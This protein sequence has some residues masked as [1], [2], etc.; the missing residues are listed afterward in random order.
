M[1]NIDEAFA[2]LSDVQSV[3][4]NENVDFVVDSYLRVISIPVRGVVLGVEGDKDVNRVTF[5]MSRTY[6]GVD[7]S[8]FQIRI[9]YAN[10]NNELN[11]FKVTEI[12]VSDDEI[13]FVWVVGADAVAYVGNVEFVVRFIKLSGSNIIQELNTTLATAKSLIGLSV[14]GEISPVQREDLLAHFYN[15]IDAYSETKKNEI[16]DSIPEDYTALANEVDELKGDLNDLKDCFD[17]SPNLYNTNASGVLNGAYLNLSDGVSIIKDLSTV[18]WRTSDF[19]DVSNHDGVI[20]LKRNSSSGKVTTLNARVYWYDE[21]NSFIS[22]EN[23]TTPTVS[24]P[25]NARYVRIS[26]EISIQYDLKCSVSLVDIE[27]IDDYGTIYSLKEN[28]YEKGS[29]KNYD[30]VIK[31]ITNK[32]ELYESPNLYD[33]DDT[34]WEDGY[35][36]HSG[37][38]GTGD[39]KHK[40]F[41]VSTGDTFYSYLT[42]ENGNLESYR[43]STSTNWGIRFVTAYMEDGSVNSSLGSSNAIY[44]YVVPDGVTKICISVRTNVI[45]CLTKNVDM[46]GMPYVGKV[47]PYYKATSDFLNGVKID[48]PKKIESFA[49]GNDGLSVQADTMTNETIS[50]EKNSI[51]KNKH[52]SFFSNISSFNNLIIGHGKTDYGGNY[53]E[54]TNTSLTVYKYS[55]SPSVVKTIEHGLTLENNIGVHINVGNK[56]LADITICSNG[57]IAEIHEATWSGT[58]GNIFAEVDESTLLE[59][60]RFSWECDDYRKNIWVFG[61]SYLSIDNIARWT[62]WL[63]QWC[64]DNV[65][66]NA[67]P[68]EDSQGAFS[69]LNVALKHGTPKY[70][71][72][73]LGMNDGDKN[74]VISSGYKTILNNVM[75]ICKSKGI[76]LVLATIP[77]TPSIE[78]T[79]KNEYVKSSGYKYIDF[80]LSVGA[81][82]YPSSWFDGMLSGDNVHPSELGAKSLAMNAI[83]DLPKFMQNL[84]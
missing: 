43:T 24:I 1:A 47:E 26:E 27:K 56:G 11:Y 64:G 70:L 8:Q 79:Y 71:V 83:A 41:D 38:T 68:G 52:L 3:S 19:I 78:H 35:I 45:T 10:A 59:N 50:L 7:M 28:Y 6:K 46:I 65:L 20:Y 67:F 66:V 9:N 63:L 15:E 16:L 62:Y 17:I 4:V 75:V 54:I 40:F 84:P 14:D 44:K 42:D 37:G 82:E 33:T 22:G 29:G 60:V 76:E 74:G 32:M 69:D 25:N 48:I 61:D 36:S 18:N 34:S 13:V 30:D 53:I 49:L 57:N 51:K 2:A 21:N 77:N 80:A 23:T 81:T 72:W 39:Y 58:N 73:C 31:K 12:T 5:R 55:F